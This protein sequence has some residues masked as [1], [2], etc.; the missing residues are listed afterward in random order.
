MMMNENDDI[1]EYIKEDINEIINCYIKEFD[2]FY[3]NHME[4]EFW[5]Y[6][7][8]FFDEFEERKK[9]WDGFLNI[10]K[11]LNKNIYFNTDIIKMFIE[12]EIEEDEDEEEYSMIYDDD[13]TYNYFKK[14]LPELIEK[15]IDENFSNNYVL[16]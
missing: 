10:L 16:K 12:D 8:H 4:N 11:Y 1:K 5:D 7:S 2:F 14:T 6:S 15:Y 9:N 13:R 3:N